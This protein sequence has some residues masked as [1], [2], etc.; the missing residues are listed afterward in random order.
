MESPLHLM[1]GCVTVTV[2]GALPEKLLNLCAGNGLRFWN[3]SPA[4]GY[5][6]TMTIYRRDHSRLCALAERAQCRI[7]SSSERG[8][9]R[10]ARPLKRRYA[11]IIGVALA[12]ALLF[13]SSLFIW[14][15]DV[16]G[17][18]TVSDAEILAALDECGVGVGSFWPFMSSDLIRCRV[19][20]RVP[21]LKWLTVNVR[22]SHASVIVREATPK[23]ELRDEYTPTDITAAKAGIITNIMAYAGETQVVKGQTVDQGELLVSGGVRSTLAQPRFLHACADIY[24]RVWYDLTAKC[25]LKAAEKR[26]TGRSTTRY[27]LIFGD[28]RINFYG[29]S[30]ISGA[31][32]DKII[33]ERSLAIKGVFALPVTLVKETLTEFETVYSEPNRQYLQNR[34]RELLNDRLARE[35]G[36]DG[37][38]IQSS[39]SAAVQDGY[40]VVTLHAECVE[41]IAREQTMSEERIEEIRSLGPI[42]PQY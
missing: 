20:L 9:P 17:N 36:E 12:A 11:F 21:E 10:T 42:Q 5:S 34:L 26:Y 8:L 25:P 6:L 14:D 30:G 1:R 4:S 16:Y 7:T 19:I 18:E 15:L 28:E 37:T 23:P 22:G 38:L 35:L 32:C 13:W 40:L 24:A 27:A 31:G 41:N 29:N 2:E 39:F 3:A 33:S